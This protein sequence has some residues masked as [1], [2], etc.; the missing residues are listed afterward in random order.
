MVVWVEGDGELTLISP[1]DFGDTSRHG[2]ED[3]FGSANVH[4]QRRD[5]VCSVVGAEEGEAGFCCS[6]RGVSISLFTG[7]LFVCRL[8][9][10]LCIT[11]P[12]RSF[13]FAFQIALRS[14]FIAS[15]L[16]PSDCE[17]DTR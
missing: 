1:L 6:F 8:A 3:V 4:V 12:E 2:A 14:Q 10:P 15:C 13:S 11:S 9:K 7:G 17:S 16:N 5:A